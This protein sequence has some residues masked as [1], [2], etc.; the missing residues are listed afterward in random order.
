MDR[1]YMLNSYINENEGNLVEKENAEDYLENLKFRIN[2]SK[3]IEEVKKEVSIFLENNNVPTQIRDDLIKI[4][5]SFNENTDLYQVE[6]YLEEYLSKNLEQKEKDY[7]N[8]NDTVNEIKMDLIEDVRKNLEEVGITTIGNNENVIDQIQSEDDVYKLKNNVENATDYFYQRNNAIG[9]DNAPTLE[10][11]V[12]VMNDAINNPNYET[13][14]ET[15]KEEQGNSLSTESFNGVEAKEDG[16]V[17]ISGDAN[18]ADSM[19]FAAMMTTMLVTTNNNLSLDTNL[20]MKFIKNQEDKSNFKIIYGDFPLQNHPENKL[21]PIII[22]KIQEQ[23]KQYNP[24]VNYF[25]VLNSTSIELS[26]ALM[27]INNHVLKENGD[28]KMA[29]KNGG[30]NHEIAFS[31]DENYADISTAFLESGAM[32]SHDSMENN[33]VRVNNSTPGEQLMILNATLENLNQRE[34]EQNNMA[35]QNQ[36]QKQL[37]Y[38]NNMNE[39]ANVNKIFLIVI[40]IAEILLLAFGY[41]YIFS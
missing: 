35:L 28:F 38:P 19:N 30:V 2:G 34:L 20:D 7:Q 9:E 5:D 17:E 37:V 8:S 29:I 41:F 21:D 14:L 36:Y 12:E 4:C 25:D 18:L 26:T 16:S 10:I 22:A 13:I 40:A 1:S 11:P 39:A 23:A 31:M 15:A 24:N 3:S 32:V 6:K 33:I 27:I